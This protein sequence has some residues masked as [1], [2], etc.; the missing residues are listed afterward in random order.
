MD[1]PPG[2]GVLCVV[3]CRRRDGAEADLAVV[4]RDP[5]GTRRRVA[6]EPQRRAWGEACDGQVLAWCRLYGPDP[7]AVAAHRALAAAIGAQLARA[8]R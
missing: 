3:G 5:A 6:E 1:V 7:D 4:D 8:G 2:L